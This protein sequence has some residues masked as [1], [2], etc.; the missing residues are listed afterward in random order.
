MFEKTAHILD[1]TVDVLFGELEKHDCALGASREILVQT[2][3]ALPDP[4]FSS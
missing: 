2:D 3:E 4:L 1:L